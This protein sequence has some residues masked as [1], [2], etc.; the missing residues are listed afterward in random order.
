VTFDFRKP[1]LPLRLV[2]YFIKLFL[3]SPLGIPL[4]RLAERH[5][6]HGEDD[7]YE[8]TYLQL[9]LARL[10]AEFEGY[11]IVQ[12]SD[13]HIGTWATADILAQAI[14]EVNRQK[15]DLV[16]ITGDF[17][18]HDPELFAP[19]MIELLRDINT[20]DGVV[21]ILGNHDHWAN[22][23][24]V[25]DILKN[26]GVKDLSNTVY[27]IQRG[28]SQ[29]HIAGVDDQIEK[30]DDLSSVLGQLPP[31]GSAIL[32]AHE[33]DFAIHSDKSRRFDLQLSGHTHGGQVNLPYI[34]PVILPTYGKKFPSGLYKLDHMFL[35]TNRG[36]GTA[37]LQIRYNC[38]AEITVFDLHSNRSVTSHG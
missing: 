2:L 30:L 36:L 11:R 10:N 24:I 32:L 31:E 35:Y 1:D 26:A 13:F 21:A 22:P 14:L 23:E 38:K 16:A 5:T 28:K 34:G 20:S 33:P 18:T 27:R 29:L 15:P 9:H 19:A 6:N 17:V 37:D 12:I 25:R 8:V 4:L 3:S 7:W